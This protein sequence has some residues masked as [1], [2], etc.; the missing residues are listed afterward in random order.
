[1]LFRSRG[2]E[3]IGGVGYHISKYEAGGAAVVGGISPRHLQLDEYGGLRPQDVK[4]AIQPDDPHFARTKLVCVENTFNGCVQDQA[5]MKAVA[6]I[7]HEYGLQV[8]LDGARLMNASIASGLSAADLASIADTV[9]LCLSK[10]LGAPVG[11]VLC[12]PKDFI[13]EARRNRKLLGGGLRQSGV[14]AA[15]GL[16]ALDNNV[17]RLAQ[18]H[19]NAQELAKRLGA[20]DGLSIDLD[21]V[22]T[23]MIWMDVTRTPQ[24]NLS[25]HMLALGMLIS[26]PAP[27]ARLVCHIDFSKEQIDQ[28][29]D[30]FS[31]WL[32]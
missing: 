31:T 17:Q 20:I 10:G 23:N 14:L 22:H 9:S 12:G 28:V 15:C 7:A 19:E 32:T 2:E 27:Q 25:E 5:N 1:V 21:K 30:G 16:Y 6:T 13:H 29:V 18:D 3:Y 11:S 4:A 24:A 26:D 8:H